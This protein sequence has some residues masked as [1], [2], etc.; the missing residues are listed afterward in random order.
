M[1]A[2][3]WL[4]A[5]AP[6]DWSDNDADASGQ[7]LASASHITDGQEDFIEVASAAHNTDEKDGE[8]DADDTVIHE[9]CKHEFAAASLGA[10]RES[11]KHIY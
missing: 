5:D 4:Q 1:N 10:E 7:A 11:T 8:I 2:L 9:D 6:D 3:E